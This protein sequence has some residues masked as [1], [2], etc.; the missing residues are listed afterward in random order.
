[1][2]KIPSSMATQH[3]D[4]ANRYIN[5]QQEPEEAIQGL[6]A[7]EKGGLGIEEI[8]I[9]FEGKLT[10][11]H[12]TSQIALGL[13][14]Q[15]IIPGEAVALTPRIPN[16]KKEPVFRQLMSIMSLVETNVLSYQQT[17]V[18]AITETI[19]PMV[20]T[21]IELIHLQ[22]RINSVIELGNK[23]Y[24]IQFPL[25]SIKIIPLIESVPALVNVDAIL[26]EYYQNSLNDGHP[27]ERLRIMLARSDSAMSYGMIAS[28]LSVVIAIDKALK[29]GEANK[30]AVSPILGCG[31]LPFRGHFTAE[32]LDRIYETYAGVK[33]YTIQSAL[34][35]DHGAEK[36]KAV[37]NCLKKNSDQHG[38][39]NFAPA[40][41]A[42]MQESIGIFTKYY[43]DTFVKT[44]DIVALLSK[45]MPKNRDRLASV[46]TGLEYIREIANMQEIADLVEDQELKKELLEI[47]TN[48]KC[49]VPR[50]ISFTAAL[51]TLGLPPEFIGVGRGLQEVQRKYGE[52]G[53]TKLIDFYPQLRA[54]LSFAAQYVNVKNAK[55]IIDEQARVAYQEDYQL[56]CE[57]LEIDN[58]VDDK[59][60]NAWYQMLLKSIR[61]II[62]H[63]IEKED[64]G[65][66]QEEEK[67]L[68]DWIIKMATIRGSLG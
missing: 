30:V 58:A 66:G 27:I 15:G 43:M 48:V 39:R 6:T 5:I 53:I 46:K 35:Y 56:A 59:S 16:A 50:A 1:M 68:N 38:R 65:Q 33:T 22:E 19:V 62:L 24:E 34:R 10:P 31:A 21:G 57:I 2:L 7:Q 17:G 26:T 47:N 36:T 12:Q 11:Y 52:E 44:I 25:N 40:D 9:D 3:P 8:M 37:V 63:L 64:P 61:P 55:G 49:S 13:I 32:N 67:I 54:D 20:E 41:L 14:G 29:W 45:Y 18:Q 23:N 4:N 28:V 51:Y 42:L 60:E